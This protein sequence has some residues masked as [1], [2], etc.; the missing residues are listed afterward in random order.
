M[1]PGLR[2]RLFLLTGPLTKL[3]AL[4]SN[5]SPG[6]PKRRARHA[7]GFSRPV[8][9]ISKIG[10]FE[11]FGHTQY[12]RYTFAALLTFTAF[13]IQMLVRG[14]LVNELTGS[15]FLVSLVPVLLMAPMLV[16]TLVGGELADRFKRTRVIMVGESVSAATYIATAALILTDTVEAWHMLALTGVQGISGAIIGPARQSLVGDLVR[17]KLQR[18]AIGLSP[19]IFNVAQI[20]GPLIGGIVLDTR[21]AG[22]AAV[23]S[24]L[25]ILPAIPISARLKPVGKSQMAHRGSS[26]LENIREGARYVAGHPMLRWYLLAGFVLIITVNTWGALFPPLAKEVLHRGAGGLAALQVGV[27][28]GS[29][30]GSLIAVSIG[31]QYGEKKISIVS[32]LA[33]TGLVGALA[34]SENFVLS[35]VIVGLAAA[36][37]TVYFVTNMVAMQLTAAPEFRSRVISVRFIMFGFGPFGMLALGAI[38]EFFGTQLA[39]GVIAVTGFALLL[40]VTVFVR[41]GKA[42]PAQSRAVP[43][44]PAVPTAPQQSPAQPPAPTSAG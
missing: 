42:A 40:L 24:A 37:A 18:A 35:V 12:R 41:V 1:T 3:P 9:S 36:T 29:L 19:A 33:F 32:G 44:S 21:G 17:P 30:V 23:V 14:W 34:S 13:F 2:P 25:L 8:Y 31:Q 20:T 28:V 27:G 4:H 26:F 7:G 16:F 6:S 38:A 5:P 15:P 10:P 11:P 39:L 22:A 43:A